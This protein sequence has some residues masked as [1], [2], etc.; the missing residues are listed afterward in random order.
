MKRIPLILF[1]ILIIGCGNQSTSQN[2]SE[3]DTIAVEEAIDLDLQSYFTNELEDNIYNIEYD[4]DNGTYFI[5]TSS[6]ETYTL[7]KTGSSYSLYD[8]QGNVYII[9]DYGNGMSTMYAPDGEVYNSYDY[10]NGMGTTYKP[11]GEIYNT[12]NYGNCMST[13]YGPDG[14]V[15]NSYD[16]GNGMS[17]TYGPDGE[18]TN[19][20]YY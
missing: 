4:T 2:V 1:C 17:T 13:T 16:Y 10:G 8:S 9:Y 20:Y 14:E 3:D 6:G 5:H 12:Y 15:Y 19:T 18:I 7:I 11:D